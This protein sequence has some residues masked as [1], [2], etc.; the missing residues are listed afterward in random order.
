MTTEASRP[1]GPRILVVDDEPGITGMLSI[2]FEAEGYSVTTARS[3][4]EGLRR[5]EETAPDL[6]LTDLRMPDGTGFDILKR[7]REA[8]PETPVVMIT[9][10]TST[11]TAIEAL[12][13]QSLDP[14][15][16][17]IAFVVGSSFGMIG[18]FRR[19]VEE[20]QA[21]LSPYDVSRGG[22][23]GGALDAVTRSGTNTFQGS[24]HVDGM[25]GRT[26]GGSPDDG[27]RDMQDLLDARLGFQTGG[28][29]P[30][31]PVFYYVAGE[32]NRLGYPIDRK[33]DAREAGGTVSTIPSA[34]LTALRTQLDTLVHYDPGS[35][36]HLILQR[37]A[38][39]LFARLDARISEHHRAGL[40]YNFFRTQA[41]R[42]PEVGS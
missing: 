17:F 37:N 41:D 6:V 25:T 16:S 34:A 19:A 26:T 42:S 14:V 40:R 7:T 9:A 13:A 22:F 27:R 36:E 18:D 11:K 29:L 5:L 20:L 15:S 30:G 33:F 12:K 3:C 31:S 32:F 10:Y 2:V 35:S 4:A 1:A 28:P 38:A 24:L 23:T 21:A 39:S 8:S